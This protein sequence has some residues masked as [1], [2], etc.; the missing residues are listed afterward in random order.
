MIKL[1]SNCGFCQIYTF[2]VDCWATS[3]V[4]QC[5]QKLSK[6]QSITDIRSWFGLVNQVANYAQLRN[7]LQPFKPFLSFKRKFEWLDE[8]FET[9]ISSKK[10]H[11]GHKTW[12]RNIW[13]QSVH[14]LATR[15]VYPRHWLLPLAAALCIG[16]QKTRMLRHRLEKNIG[17]ITISSYGWTTLCP[18]WRPGSSGS[19]LGGLR[20]FIGDQTPQV[21]HKNLRRSYPW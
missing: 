14:V 11:Q 5:N 17:R 19:L 6:P 21:T 2:W 18:H 7:L 13:F 3:Q 20:W 16:V 15:L 1:W 4:Y 10:N 12:R 9:F 8:L